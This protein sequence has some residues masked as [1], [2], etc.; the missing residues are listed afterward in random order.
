MFNL[1]QPCD[2]TKYTRQKPANDT[3]TST[4]THTEREQEQDTDRHE[5]AFIPQVPTYLPTY[6]S[7]VEMSI[8][9]DTGKFAKVTCH[10]LFTP[11]YCKIQAPSA[12][13]EYLR[14]SFFR[15]ARYL[16]ILEVAYL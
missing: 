15:S 16:R 1:R 4:C 6:L 11:K 2:P 14:H 13:K 3:S 8:T 9:K 12:V 7:S 10:F 5:N